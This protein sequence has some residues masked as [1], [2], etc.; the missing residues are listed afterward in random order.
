MYLDPKTDWGV[1]A[2]QP[3]FEIS[4]GKHK[5]MGEREKLQE[6]NEEEIDGN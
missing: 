5:S 3:Y 1:I 4:I 2:Y 6:K